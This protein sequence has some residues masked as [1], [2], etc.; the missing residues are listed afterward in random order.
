MADSLLIQ[1]TKGYGSAGASTRKR[2][3]K[4]FKA[5]SGSPREDIDYNNY[6]LRQRGRLMYMGNPIAT[7]AIK[8]SRTNTVGLGL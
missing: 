7:S 4:G 3:T 6:T 2:A 1:G 5:L 8:T